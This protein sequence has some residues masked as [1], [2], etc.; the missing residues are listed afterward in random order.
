MSTHQKSFFGFKQIRRTGGGRWWAGICMGLMMAASFGGSAAGTVTTPTETATTA[1]ESDPQNDGTVYLFLHGLNSDETTWNAVAK[2][3]F[4]KRCVTLSQATDPA[5]INPSRCYRLHFS[6]NTWPHGDGLSLD[7]LGEEVGQAVYSIQQVMRP[8][9]IV[10]V[11]HSRGGLAARAYLQQ[12][13]PLPQYKLALLTIGTP[14]Q[15]TPLG[16][17]KGFMDQ[18]QVSLADVPKTV[19]VKLGGIIPTPVKLNSRDRLEFLFSPSMDFLATEAGSYTGSP[20]ARRSNQTLC[21][22][23]GDVGQLSG[24]VNV[25]GQMV[26]RGMK[27]GGHTPI[28][29]DIELNL[30]DD[31]V[32]KKLFPMMIPKLSGG[33]FVRLRDHVLADIV[34]RAHGGDFCSNAKNA[35]QGGWAWSKRNPDSW[36]CE[37]D[38]IVPLVSQTFSRLLPQETFTTVNL[39]GVYHTEQ[40]QRTRNILQLLRAMLK[41][42]PDFQAP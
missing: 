10:L 32:I 41:N 39:K 38:G 15:G 4:A 35:N 42:Q 1:T 37:G 22:L 5:S 28:G 19:R 12:P 17:V 20:C 16:R 9:A 7:E 13:G 11:G 40:T 23:N 27:L 34:D 25:F 24:L 29:E 21:Q 8:S 33:D 36:A 26:S 2:R 6:D 3:L 30:L 14:H 31:A 18:N